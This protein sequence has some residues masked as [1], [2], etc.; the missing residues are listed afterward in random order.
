[1]FVKKG[2]TDAHYLAMSKIFMAVLL[3]ASAGVTALMIRQPDGLVKTFQLLITA[4]AG[5][6]LVYMLRWYWWRVSAWSELVA[7][8]G[9]VL[10]AGVL[11]V[12][13]SSFGWHVNFV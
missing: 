1:R 3:A 7:V 9:S 8:L 4:Q 5:T 12:G 13:E 6:G 2:A 10:V 11:Y